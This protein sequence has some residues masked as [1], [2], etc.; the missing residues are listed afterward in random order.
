MVKVIAYEGG[1][2]LFQSSFVLRETY[3]ADAH[4]SVLGFVWANEEISVDGRRYHL[5]AMLQFELHDYCSLD[6]SWGNK[7]TI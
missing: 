5:E 1:V 6:A 7:R 2:L 4:H 3:G